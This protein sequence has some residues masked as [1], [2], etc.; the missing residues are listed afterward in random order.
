MCE[1][2]KAEKRPSNES[3]GIIADVIF[4]QEYKIHNSRNITQKHFVTVGKIIAALMLLNKTSK[5]I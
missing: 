2:T 4:Q 3:E 1:E 5:S